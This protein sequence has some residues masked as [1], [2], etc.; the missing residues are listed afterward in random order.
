MESPKLEILFREARIEGTFVLYD[1]SANS[2]IGY[3]KVRAETRF[4]P[5][6][7]FKIPN[8]LIGLSTK[9]VKNVDE[10]LPYGGG[11]QPA[12][13]WEKDMSLRDAIKISNIPIYQEL[14]RRIGLENMQ[15][16]VAELH[17][18]NAEIG[19]VVDVFW[20]KGPLEISPIEQTR[21]LADLAE[22]KLPFPLEAQE[23]VCE[24]IMVEQGNGWTLF[25][26]TGTVAQQNP[27]IGWWVGWV[28]KGGRIYSFAINLNLQKPEDAGKRVELGRACLEVLEIL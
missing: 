22:K 14:A 21:F 5:A 13:A 11:K 28:E 20:L 24:I 9:A 8:S 23:A 25:A 12:A 3:N 4:I 15:K 26:K 10:I 27:Q 16:S 17:Y 2:F 19:S 7:T 1:R 6:S 18:G